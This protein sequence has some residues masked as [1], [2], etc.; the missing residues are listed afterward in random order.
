M[1]RRVKS[2][3]ENKRIRLIKDIA[4]LV[5]DLYDEDYVP[6][7]PVEVT[8]E[9]VSDAIRRLKKKE[10][11]ITL[12]DLINVKEVDVPMSEFGI[13]EARITEFRNNI[14]GGE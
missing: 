2:L 11:I 6:R 12:E 7:Q 3:S 14:K 5:D 8:D 9:I 10:R 4:E 13:S 1:S